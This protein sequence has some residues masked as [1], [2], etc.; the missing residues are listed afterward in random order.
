V[1]VDPAV[2]ALLESGPLTE[3]LIRTAAARSTATPI[4]DVRASTTY[5]RRLLAGVL[6]RGF[7]DAGLV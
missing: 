5:R 7:A 2:A 4:S 6:L 3:D 1:G